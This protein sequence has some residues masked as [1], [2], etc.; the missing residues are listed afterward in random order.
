VN[1]LV[2]TSVEAERQA[3]L[4]AL[5]DSADVR[6][7]VA[8]VGPAEAAAATSAE[9]AVGGVDLVVCAGIAGGFAPLRPGDIAVASTIE[10]ADLGADAP[11]GFR[12]LTDLGFGRVRYEVTPKLGVELADRTGGRLGTVLTV[13]TATGTAETEA[14]LARR[15]PDAVAEAMEGAG[16]AAAAVYHDVPV[17]E[18]RAISNVVGPRERAS[19]RIDEALAALGTA[20]A[21]AFGKDGP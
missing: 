21:A 19:W 9:L 17:A 11:D 12:P 20:L 3:I 18:I 4:S 2:V 13:A 7:I 16:V 8:G 1:V 5:P 10:F 15:F 6:A 14:R